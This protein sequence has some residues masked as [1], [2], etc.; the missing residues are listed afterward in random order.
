MGGSFPQRLGSQS[1]ESSDRVLSASGTPYGD[2]T[3]VDRDNRISISS[4]VPESEQRNLMTANVS[5]IPEDSVYRLRANASVESL[6]T[7]KQLQYSPGYIGEIGIAIQIPEAP[8]GDQEVRWGYWGGDDGAY[9]GWDSTSPF[10]QEIRN[11]TRGDKIRPDEWTNDTSGA[12]VERLLKR[13]AITRQL[14]ALYNFGG[15]VFEIYD[16]DDQQRLEAKTVHNLS[17]ESGT[18]LSR[19]NNPLRVEVDNPDAEDFDVFLADRQATIRGQFTASNRVKSQEL[20]D[21]SLSGETWVPVLTI[22]IKEPFDT[23][24]VEVLQLSSLSTEDIFVQFRSGAGSTADGDYAPPDNVDPAETAIEVDTTPTADIADGFHRIQ[25]LLPGGGQGN[26]PTPLGEFETA[27]LEV[28]RD[29]PMTVF[30]KTTGAEGGTL[31]AANLNWE[32]S[33]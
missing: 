32:E 17:T 3:T 23:V 26:A 9:F 5:L 2:L 33:W 14:L 10:V 7:V 28:K 15:I 20:T 19:Q 11:G 8:T 30:V 25:R 16:R 12:T 1:E 21:V 4:D 24:D 13:G 27:D 18:T 22:R 6:E 29:R 31:S